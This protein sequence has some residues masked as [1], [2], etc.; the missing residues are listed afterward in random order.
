M[1]I[2][3]SL[4]ISMGIYPHSNASPVDVYCNC[5]TDEMQPILSM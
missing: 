1:N 5:K 4:K 3:F 2:Y